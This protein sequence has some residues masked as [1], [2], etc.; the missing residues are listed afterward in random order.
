MLVKY[1][2][3]YNEIF[4]IKLCWIIFER[5]NLVSPRRKMLIK[6]VLIFSLNLSWVVSHECLDCFNVS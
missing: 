6:L 1:W 4:V 2:E 5:K 3:V